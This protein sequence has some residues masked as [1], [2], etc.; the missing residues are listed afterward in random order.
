MTNDDTGWRTRFFCIDRTRL[1][2]RCADYVQPSGLLALI[3]LAVFWDKIWDHPGHRS[4]LEHIGAHR[5]IGALV[6]CSFGAL[7]RFELSLR[8]S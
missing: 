7:E 4:I 8:E 2:S 6:L 1:E 3:C 5:S